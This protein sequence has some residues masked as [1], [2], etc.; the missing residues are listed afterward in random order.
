MAL[1]GARALGRGDNRL[2]GR[3]PPRVP[4]SA[5]PTPPQPLFTPPF[6]AVAP[7]LQHLP[8]SAAQGSSA[9]APNTWEPSTPQR[10]PRPPSGPGTATQGMSP[11]ALESWAVS[12][13]DYGVICGWAPPLAAFYVRLL[14]SGDIQQRIHARFL[15]QNFRQLSTSAAIDVVRSVVIG[16]RCEVGA[17][18]EFFRYSQAPGD[19]VDAYVSKSR[20]LAAECSFQCPGCY[21]SLTEYVLS[22]K[23]VM[24]LSN[25][26]MK[27][28]VLRCFSRLKSVS[29]VVN[30]CEIIEAADRVADGRPAANVAPVADA[31]PTTNHALPP[32]TP[33]DAS[34]TEVAAANHQRH[35]GHHVTQG[36]QKQGRTQRR[37]RNCGDGSCSSNDQ[38]PARN[39]TC[40]N[41][42][43]K[44]HFWRHC[45]SLKPSG[46]SARSSNAVMVGSV[47]EVAGLP[48]RVSH[49]Q[50]K[51]ECSTTAIAD[52]GAQVCIA[53]RHLPKVLGLSPR[54][55]QPPTRTISHV[56]GGGV[57]LLGVAQ[58]CDHA[59][60][61]F[62][63]SAVRVLESVSGQ[64]V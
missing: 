43:R 35:G 13:E 2:T 31:R 61:A 19:S 6:T 46:E 18:S 23:V 12:V 63:D 53:G 44:G 42:K 56:A 8:W 14:C 1:C 7:A 11:A 16:P 36:G 15:R 10:P 4:R 38:C 50:H 64:L 21:G 33:P 32:P 22:R 9:L 48:V 3:T 45:R 54:Q 41:C 52:T 49:P 60:S 37:C 51:T 27:A 30:Q 39:S 28:E 26:S 47:D 25:R 34:E 5:A 55:L 24:G 29:D 57:K 59:S 58:R 20:A 62:R 17:W 40:R